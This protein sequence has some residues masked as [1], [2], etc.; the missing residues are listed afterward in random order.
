LSPDGFAVFFHQRYSRTVVML[1]AMG[2]SRAEAEDAT[3]EAMIAAWQQWESI[4]EP[5]AWVRT[6]ALRKL[7]KLSHQQ[8]RTSPLDQATCQ[9]EGS[10]PDLAVFS[11]EQQQVL[12]LLRRLP[13]TQRTVAALYYD[14][15]STEEIAHLTGKPAATVRSHLRH[16]RKTLTEVIASGPS[17]S[18]KPG[19]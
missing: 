6:T 3:Q 16:A 10:E 8:P 7:W 2:A 12:S 19:P 9:P 14:G 5:A 11:S 4:R 17:R 15:L 18:V 13:D 1:I